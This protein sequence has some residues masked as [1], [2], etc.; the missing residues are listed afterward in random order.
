MKKYAIRILCFL[1]CTFAVAELFFQFALP[2]S[3]W[4]RGVILDSGVRRFDGESFTSGR[5]TYGRYCKGGF[6]WRI[7]PQGW[8]SIYEYQLPENRETQ[9]VAILGDSYLEGFYSDVDEHIG[10]FLTDL[11]EERT[12]FYTF[13]MSGG[14]LSQYIALMRYEIV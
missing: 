14:I 2:A 9:M 6:L 1:I 8:N 7:N 4:P 11:L 13:A 10:V 3:E 12:S 5:F